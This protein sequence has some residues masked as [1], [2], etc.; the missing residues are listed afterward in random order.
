MYFHWKYVDESL[1]Q[2]G[3]GR[4]SQ[5]GWFFVGANSADNVVQVARDI[6]AAFQNSMAETKTETEKEFNL[7]FISMVG[8]IITAIRIISIVVI[9]IILLVLANTMAMTAR[10]R[11]SEY[12][13][14]KT[15]GFRPPHIVGLIFG[16]SL[17]IAGLGWMLGIIITIPVIQGF[18]VFL[19]QELGGFFPIFEMSNPTLLLSTVAALFV[20]LISALFP[21]TY[22]VKM[23][24]S[25]G[26]R[27]IG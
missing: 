14:L 26:L 25:D 16:E 20:G 9:L 19:T 13:V 27:Q 5:V 7:S 1:A 22:A 24:I 8:T 10:E 4:T 3:S 11:T 2:Q 21:T 18:A 17:F 12:A 23:K 15:L 6:D